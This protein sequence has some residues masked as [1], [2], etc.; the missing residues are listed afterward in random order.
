[1][2]LVNSAEKDPDNRDRHVDKNPT[3]TES[4]KNITTDLEQFNEDS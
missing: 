3:E 2:V 1:M 4:L